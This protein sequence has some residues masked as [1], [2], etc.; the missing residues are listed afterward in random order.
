MDARVSDYPPS[1]AGAPAHRV[2][3]PPIPRTWLVSIIELE[4]RDERAREIAEFVFDQANQLPTEA[5]SEIPTLESEAREAEANYHKLIAERRK[6]DAR[7]K[8]SVPHHER[9]PSRSQKLTHIGWGF[10]FAAALAFVAAATANFVIDADLYPALGANI[11]MAVLTTGITVTVLIGG[12]LCL[13]EAKETDEDKR[14]FAR[15]MALRGL[16]LG[17]AWLLLFA[18]VD[19]LDNYTQITLTQ[20]RFHGLLSFLNT[21][22]PAAEGV[23]KFLMVITQILGEAFG[24]VALELRAK[25]LKDTFHTPVCEENPYYEDLQD[26]IRA[27]SQVAADFA[28]RVRNLLELEVSLEQGRAVFSTLCIAELERFDKDC[29]IGAAAARRRS[30]NDQL[31]D[32]QHA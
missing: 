21:L 30:I 28:K 32:L 18:L 14:V 1:F 10:C 12:P 11:W 29:G 13:Y 31:K 3:L 22:L 2:V 25:R 6:T 27:A 17:I 5:L 20:H 4:A 7:F 23:A 8:R 24:A 16:T 26:R 15:Q 19:A 9:R